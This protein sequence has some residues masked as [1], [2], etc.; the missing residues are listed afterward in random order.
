[1]LS[2]SILLSLFA[3]SVA[4][5][6]ATGTPFGFAAST[7]GGG[8]VKP[9]TPTTTEELVSYLTDD[10]ARVIILNQESKFIGTEGET[11]KDRT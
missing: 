8:D 2:K 4:A 11:T 10:E 1:M 3:A 9:V 6:G 7:T 5:A